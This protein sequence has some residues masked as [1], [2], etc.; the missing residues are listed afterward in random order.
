[1]YVWN[2]HQV[3]WAFKVCVSKNDAIF[4]LPAAMQYLYHQRKLQPLRVN[5]TNIHIILLCIQFYF[6]VIF[7]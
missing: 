7:A 4:I 1:M 6:S 5:V 2:D 3:H